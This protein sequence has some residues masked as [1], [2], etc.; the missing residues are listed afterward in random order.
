M[1]QCRSCA[2]GGCCA[3]LI[4]LGI[5][6]RRPY[7]AKKRAAALARRPLPPGRVCFPPGSTTFIFE[8]CM[9]VRHVAPIFALLLL[10]IAARAD[11]WPQFRG[12][13]RTGIS[14]E[15]GLLQTWPKDGPKLL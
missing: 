13:D 9:T 5:A 11:D 14:K 2:D 4:P 7:T 6:R 1:L 10:G 15:K 12:P 3:A 8:A